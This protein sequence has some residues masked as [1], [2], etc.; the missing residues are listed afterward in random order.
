MNQYTRIVYPKLAA[1]DILFR[2]SGIPYNYNINYRH[3]SSE[4]TLQFLNF[5]GLKP[6]HNRP[7]Y[8][9]YQ[10]R[11]QFMHFRGTE[12]GDGFTRGMRDTYNPVRRAHC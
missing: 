11:H 1:E 6:S 8:G 2:Q 5:V 12:I 9:P 10:L 4:P 3:R 7:S